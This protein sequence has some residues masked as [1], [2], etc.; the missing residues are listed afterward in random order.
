MF[1]LDMPA[2]VE[3]DSSNIFTIPS[4]SERHMNMR[5]I[6]Q[7]LSIVLIIYVALGCESRPDSE[8]DIAI[9]KK[10]ILTINSEQQKLYTRYQVKH[11][12]SKKYLEYCHDSLLTITGY[13]ALLTS[14]EE[15]SKDLVD[16]YA[17]TIRNIHL[18]VYDNTAILTGEGTMYILVGKDTIYEP[19]WIAKVFIRQDGQWKMVLR[20]SG[21]LATN[22]REQV[23]ID[24]SKLN[25]LAGTYG[26]SGAVHKFIVENDSLYYSW[27]NNAKVSYYPLNDSTF[28]AKDDLSTLVF[29]TNEKGSI[30]ACEFVLPDGQSMRFQKNVD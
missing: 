22:Y 29:R 8:E 4:T 9:S 11:E 17:D 30:S 25:R 26:T 10:E 28:F 7:P 27:T 2:H 12:R 19:M 6:S 24:G 3:F 14:A 13:G 16:G 1:E 5:S 15:A 18:R 21:P 20:N 23:K